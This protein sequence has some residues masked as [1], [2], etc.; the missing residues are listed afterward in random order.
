VRNELAV[1][2]KK[3]EWFVGVCQARQ[4]VDTHAALQALET[5]SMFHAD[6]LSMYSFK[7]AETC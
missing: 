2:S 4:L 7:S 3:V 6:V 5:A 1:V